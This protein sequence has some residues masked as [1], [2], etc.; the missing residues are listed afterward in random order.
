MSIITPFVKA[1]YVQLQK[2]MEREVDSEDN[3]QE[4][5]DGEENQLQVRTFVCKVSPPSNLFAN[6][7]YTKHGCFSYKIYTLNSK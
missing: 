6:F 5:K 1:L 7:I 2:K 3:R 4:G